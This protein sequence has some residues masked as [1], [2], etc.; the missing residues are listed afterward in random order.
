MLSNGEWSLV[1]AEENVKGYLCVT[2]QTDRHL[3]FYYL[4]FGKKYG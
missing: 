4:T 2:A 1:I 3:T